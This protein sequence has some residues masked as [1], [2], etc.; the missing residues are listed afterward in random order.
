MSRYIEGRLAPS[1]WSK[2]RYMIEGTKVEFYC[3]YPVE[4]KEDGKYHQGVIEARWDFNIGEGIYYF[5]GKAIEIDL[6][7]GLIL[8]VDLDRKTEVD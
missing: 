3:G 8:R 5:K 6:Q 7:E 1:I 4:L 2:G